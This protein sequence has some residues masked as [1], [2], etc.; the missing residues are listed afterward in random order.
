MTIVTAAQELTFGATPMAGGTRFRIWAPAAADLTLLIHD[1]AAQGAYALPR[2]DMGLF[3]RLV[4]NAAAGDRYTFRIDGGADRPDPASRFQPDG[5]HGPSQVIDPAA[6]RWTDGRWGG[7]GAGDLVLYEL[8]VGTFSPEGTFRG[9]AARLEALRDLG[10]TAIELMPVADFPGDRN[11]GYDG[12]C[13][14]APSRAYGHP[15][16]L[17]ALVDRAH[18]LGLSVSLDV[19]HN[20]L[21]PE[22]AYLPEFHPGFFTDRHSTPWG[23]AVNL[24]GPGSEMV[25]RFIVDNA[26]YWIREFHFDGLRLDATHALVEND[27]GAIVREIVAAVRG[28]SSRPLF[29]HAEDH[30]NLARMIESRAAGGWGLDAV[31]ADDFH[32]VMRRLLAGDEHGYYA[33]FRGTTAELAQTIRQGWLYTGQRSQHRGTDRGTDPAGVP[34]YRFVVCLQ[35]HDQIGNR[36]TGDRLNAVVSHEAWRAASAVLLTVPMTPLLFMGQEWSAG[37]P[38]QYFTDVEAGLGRLVTEGRLREFADFPA[39]GGA[40][41]PRMIPDPQSPSTWLA[42]RLDWAERSQPE[43]AAVIALYRAL[44]ALRLDHPALGASSETSGD[45]DAPDEG[46]VVIR[47]AEHGDVFWIVARLK[48]A[49]PVDLAPLVEA[50]A[51]QD[52]A[53]KVVLSTEEPAYAVDPAPP[54]IDRQPGGPV[55]HFVRPGAVIFQKA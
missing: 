19:V 25:R 26:R 50:R 12:V 39:F 47:R 18:R 24:D 44:L 53:W 11:W 21:G 3:D 17:R 42:S 30:R 40:H 4:D 34:M 14:Y 36:A 54:Q 32:H 46:S 6:F 55:V 35:N 43:H 2:D 8:H 45:A 27:P 38:F 10:I 31:W 22:G 15:D 41:A 20:H 51:E 49:G 48:G 13:L 5:V 1:G 23:R 33:D 52:G 29:V 7:R 28:E 9:A 16:D 37:T